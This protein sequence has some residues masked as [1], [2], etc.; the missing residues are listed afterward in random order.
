MLMCRASQAR[1]SCLCVGLV[2]VWCVLYW[3]GVVP[4]IDVVRDRE[5]VVLK[6]GKRPAPCVWLAIEASAEKEDGERHGRRYART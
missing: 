1:A 3:A 6:E 4:T 2:C 5:D